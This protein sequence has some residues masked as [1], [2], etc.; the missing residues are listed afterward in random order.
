MT[1]SFYDGTVPHFKASLASLSA[2]IKAGEKYAA[3][4]SIPADDILAWRLTDD[5]LP[6]SFQVQMVTDVAMKFI[7]RVNDEPVEE[8]STD[9]KTVADLHARIEA[10]EKWIAKADPATFEKRAD[11][12]VQLQLGPKITKEVP[13]K[14]WVECYGMPNLFFHLMTAYSILRAKGVD[15]GKIL[16]ITP[17]TTSWFT[18]P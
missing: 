17:F 16:F 5:M 7:A 9:F 4:K 10:A 3:E 11:A 14:G 15:V 12:T 1:Y 8:W 2:I 18:I 13:A 6:F